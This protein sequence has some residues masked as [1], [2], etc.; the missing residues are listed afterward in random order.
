M[1]ENIIIKNITQEHYKEAI[2]IFT[3]GFSDDP[4][5]I[6][7][8][9]DYKERV[10]V[11]RCIYEMM[12]YDIVPGL[13][14]QLKGLFVNDVLS[15][16]LIYTR[17]DS[18]DWNDSLMEV[19]MRMRLKA[20]NPKVNEIGEYAIKVG[21]IKPQ[22]K[23]I[24]LNELSVKKLYRRKGF[25][26]MLIENAEM[27]VDKFPEV[28]IIALDTTNTLNVEIYKK[29]GYNVSIVFHFSGLK[30]YLMNKQVQLV[31]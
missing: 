3:E 25:A 10:K 1:T 19:V 24:Y 6:I 5:H 26:K 9:P 16:C 29:I 7:L 2:E 14:L 28:Q 12:V 17:P 31:K 27:D 13:N 22:E 4:L 20:D 8:F 18:F 15:A 30:C 23:H 21:Q 11:T